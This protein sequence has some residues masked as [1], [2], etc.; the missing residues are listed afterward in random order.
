MALN[1]EV[2][3]DEIVSHALSL[4]VFD[5]VNLH[6]PTVPPA[7]SGI[8]AAVWVQSIGPSL[9]SG[10]SST[11]ARIAF[12]IRLFQNAYSEPPDAIDPAMMNAADVLFTSLAGDFE[13]GGNVRNIDLM[14]AGGSSLSLIS[15]YLSQGNMNYRIMD[16]TVPVIVNDAWDQVA[17]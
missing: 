17:Q 2:I 4:G 11:S 8:T 1:S 6:E 14:G 9:L 16:I 10:L 13:L 7:A 3:L 5:T 12:T 15:G